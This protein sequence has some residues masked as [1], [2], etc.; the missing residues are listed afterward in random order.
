M[1]FRVTVS[2]VGEQPF[3]EKEDLMAL[4]PVFLNLQVVLV[5]QLLGERSLTRRMTRVFEME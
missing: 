3:F 1:T 5:F 2:R 4:E